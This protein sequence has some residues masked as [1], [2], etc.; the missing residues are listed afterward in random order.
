MLNRRN[1]L[2]L[3]I[4]DTAGF[5]DSAG[6]E[7][8]ASNGLAT[9]KALQNARSIRPIFVINERGWGTR[10]DGMKKLAKMVSKLFIKYNEDIKDGIIFLLNNFK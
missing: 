1:P 5:E 2:D 3:F 7:V 4:A 10:G 9:I 8:D 6:S